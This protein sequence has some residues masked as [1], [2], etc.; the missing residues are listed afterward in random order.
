ARILDAQRTQNW[1]HLRPQVVKFN[2]RQSS[3]IIT[4]TSGNKPDTRQAISELSFESTAN[5][6]RSY[7]GSRIF[8]RR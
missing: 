1:S 8:R 5:S 3:S 6:I 7:Q 4:T 2:R